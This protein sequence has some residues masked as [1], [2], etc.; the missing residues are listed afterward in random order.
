MQ[1]ILQNNKSCFVCGMI[2]G[3]HSHHCFFGNPGR[4]NSEK[5]GLKVW[6]CQRHHTG[7]DGI[8]FNRDMDLWLKKKSQAVFEETHTREEFRRIF[9]KSY[10]EED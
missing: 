1:S 7:Q 3:L 4:K 8:H 5:Y 10:L 6:L 9:G 2:Q